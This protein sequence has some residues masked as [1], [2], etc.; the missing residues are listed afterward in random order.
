MRNVTISKDKNFVLMQCE[1]ATKPYKLDINTGIVYGLRGNAIQNIPRECHRALT[2]S[3]TNIGYVIQ[4]LTLN[5][6]I[7]TSDSSVKML[8]IAD[9]L[10][11][12]GIEVTCCA[13]F[14]KQLADK[15][16]FKEYVAYAKDRISQNLEYS[17]EDFQDY[18]RGLVLNKTLGMQID[19]TEM[20]TILYYARDIEEWA[21]PRHW[22]CFKINFIDTKILVSGLMSYNFTYQFKEYC[23]LCDYLNEKVTTKPNFFEEYVRIKKAYERQKEAIDLL[24][25]EKAMDMHKAEMEFEYGNYKVIIPTCPQDIKD[26]GRNMHHCVAQYAKSCI[27]TTYPNRSYIVFIRH[28]DT[29]EQC[30]ITCEIRNGI[31]CQYFLSHDRYISNDEDKEFK[32]KYQEH[33]NNSWTIE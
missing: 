8:K 10:D 17:F 23:T 21:T 3:D 20:K 15:K 25:F 18:Q 1:G 22:K 32:A 27:D 12:L 14:Y 28:K 9:S 4:F 16:I 13:S 29:P 30:Y 19:P 31:I 7:L 6:Y 33:L 24:Q 11:N 2:F 26:E 5:R